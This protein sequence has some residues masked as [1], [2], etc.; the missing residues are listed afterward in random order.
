L[1]AQAYNEVGFTD[2]TTLVLKHAVEGAAIVRLSED[3]VVPIGGT[4]SL[5]VVATGDP[6]PTYQV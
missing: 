3:C 1:V 6:A 5:D 4:L 2:S